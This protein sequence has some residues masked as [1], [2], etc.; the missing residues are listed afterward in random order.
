MVRFTEARAIESAAKVAAVRAVAPG[1]ADT[2]IGLIGL[3]DALKE[4]AAHIPVDRLGKARRRY[5]RGVDGAR[6]PAL[7][8]GRRLLYK[9]C[10]R[11]S[12]MT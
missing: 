1:S 12:Y 4:I 2:E 11:H 9:G 6:F 10:P 5:D 3:I 8:G 7:Y